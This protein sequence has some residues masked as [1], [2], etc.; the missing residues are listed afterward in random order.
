V[1]ALAASVTP[2]LASEYAPA[3]AWLTQDPNPTGKGP[4]TTGPVEQV[5]DPRNGT[6]PVDLNPSPL[7]W[8]ESEFAVQAPDFLAT[9]SHP[10]A[11]PWT[12][13]PARGF[14]PRDRSVLD[15]GK[16]PF[17]VPADDGADPNGYYKVP[18]TAHGFA[19]TSADLPGHDR[20]GRQVTD[21]AGWEQY[22]ASGRVAVR[23]GWKQHAPGWVN[24]WPSTRPNQA[25]TRNA[26]GANQAVHGSVAEYGGLANSGGN[27]V[28]EAAL[29]PATTTT[30]P[31]AAPIVATIPQWGF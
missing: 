24:F 6:A 19:V 13:V 31:V 20:H 17:G 11:G 23:Q 27:T 9:S 10:H 12:P 7:P 21:T 25:R 5:S 26:A 28:Y 15:D 18:E 3:R 16:Y 8:S 4:V 29:P 14:T 22:T 2:S 30:A 1:T